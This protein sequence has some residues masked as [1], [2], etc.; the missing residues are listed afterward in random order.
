VIFD[1][2]NYIIRGT[3][4][5]VS[6]AGVAL[7]MGLIFGVALS[8]GRVYGGT[9]LAR[10]LLIYSSI[11]RSVPPIVLLFILYFMMSDYINLSPFWAGSIALGVISGSYQMEIFRGAFLA[12]GAGQMMAARSIGMSRMKSIW[13]IILPQALRVAVP[14]WSNEAAMVIKDSSLVYA[15]GVP[16]ILRRAQFVSARTYQPF[17]A[18]ITAAGIY[19]LIILAFNRLLS[20][21]ETRTRIP[22]ME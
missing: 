13:Y 1:V 22:S 5:T 9:L 6:V 19:F 2:I 10:A 15:L 17:I 8:L 4:I 18:Y 20:S 7:P 12:V 11:M 21:I 3:L 14:S 16:E